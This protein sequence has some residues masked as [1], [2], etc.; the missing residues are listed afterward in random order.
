MGQLKE[1]VDNLKKGKSSSFSII[2]D[3]G[4]GKSRLVEEFRNSLNLNTIQ[5][6]EGHS[7]GYSQNIP[8]FP[9][10]D[11]LSRAWQIKEGDPPDQTRQKVEKGARATLGER[12]DLIPYIG[13]LY[14]LPYPEIEQVPPEQWKAKLHEAINLILANLCKH[15]PTI[16]C[17]EDLHWADPSSVE[18][19][20]NIMTDL[21]YPVIILCMYRPIFSLFTSHQANSIKSYREIRLL[22]LSPTDA[23]SM[24]ESLLKTKTIPK[25]LQMFVRE[26]AEG[27][28]FYLEEVINSL[29][30]T[31]TLIKD[32]DSWKITRTLTEKDIPSTV[33]GVISARLDRLERETK[34]ILQEASVIRRTFLYEILKRISDLKEYIDKSLINLERLDLIK[35]ISLQPELEYIFKHA[36]IQEVVYNG[37]LMKNR[38]LIHEN[39]GQ[40]IEELYQDRLEEFY[41]MLAYHYYRSDN[42]DKACNYL[43]LSG[44]KSIRNNALWEAYHFYAEAIGVLRQMPESE[45]RKKEQIETIFFMT[46]P[47]RLLGYP[48]NSIDFLKEGEMLCRELG[49]R[50]S[51]ANLYNFMNLYYSVKGDPAQSRKYQEDT[52]MEADKIQDIEIMTP[53]GYGLCFSYLIEGNLIKVNNIAPKVIALLEKTQRENEFFGMHGN[54]HSML[55]VF[56]GFALGGVGE[57]AKGEQLCEKGVASAH[58]TNHPYSIGLA[59][60]NYG[61]FCIFKWDGEKTIKVYQSA[62]EYQEKSQSTIFLGMSWGFQGVGYYMIGEHDTAIKLLGKG[63]KMQTA[64]K[65]PFMISLMQVYLSMVH[66]DLGNFNEANALAKQAVKLAQTNREKMAEGFA[67]LQLGRTIGRMEGSQLQKAEECILAGIKVLNE[68]KIKSTLSIGFLFLGELYADAGKKEKALENLKQAEG[69]FQEMGMIYWLDRTKKIFETL[70]M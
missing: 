32:K 6:R 21:K 13:N 25:Q 58:R 9:V 65:L 7:Y 16:I 49:D 22:H 19:M 47:M 45:Q 54:P 36:L 64:M 28:P 59:Y 61:N 51:L 18:L 69:L 27:N 23:Q 2:G 31:D 29:I 66:F 67:W 1:A 53:C 50:R 43:K 38:R 17:I 20:R 41:E 30:E 60:L 37:L 33:Q 44:N 57:F 63:I 4:T 15:A 39:I 26:K 70:K 52:F 35:T 34:R 46:V 56:Y 3:A 62:I 12:K 55:H 42:L 14:S 68:L 5:W 11:L 24:V 8:Y 10:I 40:A 48:E